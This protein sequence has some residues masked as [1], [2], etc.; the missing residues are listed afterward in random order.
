MV[1]AYSVYFGL[2]AALVLLW[3]YPARMSNLGAVPAARAGVIAAVLSVAAF[4]V[5]IGGRYNV[6]GDFFGYLD[7]YQY[8][9]LG[10]RAGDVTFEPGFLFLIQA[11]QLFHMPERSIIV[12]SSFLQI[13]LF[14]LWLRKNPTVAP[15]AVFV[16]VALLLL[17]LNNIIRQGIAFF[18]ILLALSALSERRWIVFALWVIFGALFH[19]SALIMLPIGAV[20]YWFRIPPVSAQLTAL[21]VF[22]VAVGALFEHVVGGFTF[23][24]NLLGYSAYAD[25]TR[26][27]LAFK[28]EF[29]SSSN[30]GIYVWFVVDAIIILYSRV[31][32][33]KYEAAGYRFYHGVFL[34]AALLQP[35][36][37][38]WDFIPFSRGLFY[39]VSMRVICVAFTLHYCLNESRKVRDIVVASALSVVF[40]AWLAVA[41]TRGAAW[42]APY[43]FW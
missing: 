26:A 1:L 8:S 38:T 29:S 14:S 9:S 19:R 4:T 13:L 3:A 39:F 37:N 36:A 23:L 12:A 34:I 15:F 6:G 27:D 33:Q 18:A 20:I 24:A 42:S 40:L 21:V 41:V 25:V 10:D 5:V 30:F 22:Y 31:V 11:L 2:M 35:V 32:G 17:D 7:Y 28:K 16:C 43:Q